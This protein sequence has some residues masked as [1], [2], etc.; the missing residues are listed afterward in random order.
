MLLQHQLLRSVISLTLIGILWFP[1]Q[2]HTQVV[3][4]GGVVTITELDTVP[5]AD[6]QDTPPT[7][8]GD[9]WT[10]EV[11]SAGN[12]VIQVDTRDD[13]GDETSNLDPIAFLFDESGANFLGAADDNLGCTR[14]PV[15]GFA[16]PQIGPLF[17]EEGKYKIVVRDF[18]RAGEPQ[19][20]GGAYTLNVTGS[21]ESLNLVNDDKNIIF[22]P[23]VS[24]EA[25]ETLMNQA[26]LQTGE[27]KKDSLSKEI[28]ILDKM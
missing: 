25:L 21:V 11:E 20:N 8:M 14:A 18:N 22:D 6:F 19:C 26:E 9:A 2:G 13:N 17:L 12:V 4:A 23:L 3:E 7:L 27:E 15:C 5:N 16:C 24:K 28:E 1:I 10:F